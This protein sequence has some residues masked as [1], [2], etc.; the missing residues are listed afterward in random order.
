MYTVHAELSSFAPQFGFCPQYCWLPKDFRN[1]FSFLSLSPQS[2]W[3]HPKITDLISKLREKSSRWKK[4]SFG[5]ESLFGIWTF[6][7]HGFFFFFLFFFLYFFNFFFFF[8]DAPSHLYK[9]SCPSVG[10]SVG[11][12]VGP[13]V[14]RSV[15]PVLFSKVKRTHTRRILCR[16]SSLVFWAR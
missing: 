8:L 16:V 6:D 9:R 11:P 13:S 4:K 10:S 14:R 12:S 7:F 5:S 15:C 1:Y 3:S 2:P